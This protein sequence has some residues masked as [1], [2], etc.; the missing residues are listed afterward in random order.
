MHAI[1]LAVIAGLGYLFAGLVDLMMLA[2]LLLG[3]IPAIA[4]GSLLAA[5]APGRL[6]QVLLAIVL[7]AACAK[8]L[9]L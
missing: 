3:S 9:T 4:L 2:S 7:I 5:R 6:I 1:P 8:L